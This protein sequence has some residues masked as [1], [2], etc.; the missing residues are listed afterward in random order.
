M[1][2]NMVF[3]ASRFKPKVDKYPVEV[4]ILVQAPDNRRRDLDNLLKVC[5]DSLVNA[6][7]LQDD[8]NKCLYSLRISNTGFLCDGVG[9]IA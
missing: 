3:V 2:R 9:R 4:E 6:G 7:V 5:L 8:S 1:F